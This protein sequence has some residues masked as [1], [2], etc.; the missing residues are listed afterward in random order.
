MPKIDSKAAEHISGYIGELPEF[1]RLICERL[2]EIFLAASADLQEDWKWGPNYNSNGMVCGYGGFQK[3]VKLTFFRGSEMSDKYGLFNHCVDNI[4]LRSIKYTDVKQVEADADK[5]TEYIREA[6][7]VN[8]SGIAPIRKDPNP[9][10]IPMAL[11]KL[12]TANPVAREHFTAMSPYK[13]KEFIEQ[14]ET[15]KRPETL[16]KR[17][18][19]IETLLN[20]GLGWND[21]Y[22]SKM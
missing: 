13:Q 11:Q 8:H 5:L 9:V 18:E 22:R 6:I 7:A 16:E 1:S 19:K 3:H 21:K 12:L 4:S 2:R 15:A 14:V 20:Q 10:V 17:L